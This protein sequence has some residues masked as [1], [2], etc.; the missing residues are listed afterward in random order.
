MTSM[1]TS[2]L[3]LG[4]LTWRSGSSTLCITYGCLH[5]GHSVLCQAVNCLSEV[6][7]MHVH[8]GPCMH[9]NESTKSQDVHA[10]MWGAANNRRLGAPV[11]SS[12]VDADEVGARGD[13]RHA[14]EGAAD[15]AAGTI[16]QRVLHMR[17]GVLRGHPWRPLCIHCAHA[18]MRLC[19]VRQKTVP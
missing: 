4:L 12:A 5:S 16:A 18:S 1:G 11:R 13:E 8:L 10:L 14:R 15:L 19:H 9:G 2:H 3:G 6:S 17:Q 7:H